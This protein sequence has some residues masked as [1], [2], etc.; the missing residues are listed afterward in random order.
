MKTSDFCFCFQGYIPAFVRLG[1]QT[2]LT[3]VFFEQLRMKFGFYPAP[4]S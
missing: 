1:P 3:F 2:I 4:A